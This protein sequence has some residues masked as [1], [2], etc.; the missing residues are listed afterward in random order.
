M[1]ERVLGA[2]QMIIPWESWTHCIHDRYFA[3]LMVGGPSTQDSNCSHTSTYKRTRK[4]N[5]PEAAAGEAAARA[6]AAKAT[7]MHSY[8]Q[9]YQP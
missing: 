7:G 5:D 2:I 1:L 3:N 4:K 6:A 9:K 8:G